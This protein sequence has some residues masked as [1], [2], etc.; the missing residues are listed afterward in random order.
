MSKRFAIVTAC[1]ILI[2]SADVRGQSAPPNAPEALASQYVDSDTG[3]TLAEAIAR[4]SAQEPTL[5]AAR[6]ETDVAAGERLQ[7]GLRPNPTVSFMQQTEPGGTDSQSRIEVQ[8]PL[9]LFRKDGRVAVA[10]QELQATRQR[11]SDRERLLA[12]DVR[13]KYGEVV[14]A[15]REL[16]VSDRLVA[17]TIRQSELLRARVD[18]GGAP[19]LERNMVEV[20][21]RRLEAD[22]FLQAGQVDRAM[23]ELKRLLGMRASASL[24]LRDSLEQLVTGEMALPLRPDADASAVTARADVQEADVRIRVADARIDRARREGRVD[25]SLFGSYMR[26][27]AGFPQLGIGAQGELTPVRGLFHYVS[28]GAVLTVPLRNRNQGAIAS[29][30]AERTGATARLNAAQLTAEAEIAAALARDQR[31]RSAIAV[32]RGG[33]R[34]LARQNLDVVTQTYELGRGTVFDVLAEQRRYLDLERAYSI[35]LREAYEARTAVRR[36]LGDIR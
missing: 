3:V 11:V 14:A 8:W 7:A 5:R 25:L 34:D 32:Y 26:M 18:Q 1:G 19:P 4:A 29:A 27:D 10:E 12:A 21:L 35:A 33:A 13:M 30:Q 17:A 23:I 22:R 31:A 20:E 9:D 24:Q 6:T 2:W 16:S 28:A 15:I 36:A